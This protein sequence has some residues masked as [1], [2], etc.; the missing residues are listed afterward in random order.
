MFNIRLRERRK[1]CGFTQQQMAD[2]INLQLRSY[3]FYESGQRSPSLETL[4]KIADI[5]NVPTDYLLCRDEFLQS[6]G[7]CV[8]EF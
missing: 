3:Q 4:I 8:D 5:L 1:K 2:A 7:V 6:L